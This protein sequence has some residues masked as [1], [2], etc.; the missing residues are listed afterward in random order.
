[1]PPGE[2]DLEP[3][4]YSIAVE[5]EGYQ[6]WNSTINLESGEFKTSPSR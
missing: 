1:M 6:T 3:G 2:V 4:I 5:R